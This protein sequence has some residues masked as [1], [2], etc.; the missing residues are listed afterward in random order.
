MG[1]RKKAKPN[2]KAEA[3]IPPPTPV[4]PEAVPLPETPGPSISSDIPSE[5]QPILA[6]QDTQTATSAAAN[7]DEP[8]PP[9]PTKG[10]LGGT[11]PRAAKAAPITQVAKKSIISAGKVISEV[12]ESAAANRP[13]TPLGQSSPLKAPSL[14]LS[15]KL[16]TSSRSLPVSA[17]TTK[18]N[19]SSSNLSRPPETARRKSFEGNPA[20][21]AAGGSIVEEK[22]IP[23]E[24]R[25]TG[26]E[27]LEGP[28]QSAPGP[29]A[30]RPQE[31]LGGNQAGWL[32]WFSRGDN[33]PNGSAQAGPDSEN[34]PEGQ[35][36]KAKEEERIKPAEVV[37]SKTSVQESTTAVPDQ[38]R[39][40]GKDSES[41]LTKT[42]GRIEPPPPRSW[43]PIWGT[44]GAT[45]D[46]STDATENINAIAAKPEESE[47]EPP[48]IQAVSDG[49]RD[50]G[51]SSG[52]T[53]WS[54]GNARPATSDGTSQP[55]LGKLAVAGSSSESQPKT[56]VVAG[57]KR[58]APLTSKTLKRERPQSLQAADDTT[59]PSA[60]IT[61]AN[62]NSAVAVQAPPEAEST[63]PLS[64]KPLP[65]AAPG[66]KNLIL[67]PLKRT[68]KPANNPGLLEQ[69]RS[70][71]YVA[72]ASPPKHVNLI[73]KP[74]PIKKAL[75][76]GVHGYFP[77]PLL[78]SVLGQPTGTSIKFAES[79]ATAIQKWTKNHGYTC[80]V[81]KIALE[82][83]GKIE[84]RVELLW[85]LLLNWMDAIT[86]ADFILV[87]CHS[88]GVPVAIMLVAK[89][90]SFGCLHGARIGIC[91][92]AGVNLGPFADYKSRWISG[93]AGELFEFARPD[94]TVSKDYEAALGG[95]VRYGVKILYIGS[96]D[97]QLVS[98]EV[99][100]LDFYKIHDRS[101]FMYP[102]TCRFGGP[103]PHYK[104]LEGAARW[105]PPNRQV[106]GYIPLLL[107]F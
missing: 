34:G 97:D 23:P 33:G 7:A 50:T 103:H 44:S 73:E 96:I 87:A 57:H 6:N 32:G 72:K 61:N 55:T 107:Q 14:Y 19:V 46:Q 8:I 13:H 104:G 60:S 12:A 39:G 45:S 20:E 59:T 31:N 66:A 52:W 28:Q 42:A 71:L 47:R 74:L 53:F 86:K 90:I 17:T 91:A 11:W 38:V 5:Y 63:K 93:S 1:P 89:L 21:L 29:A 68:Y 35:G 3:D 27:Q 83:E 40:D 62:G 105:W 26:S 106:D 2:P 85:K 95:V 18:V 48:E 54:R 94:S 69:L 37:K 76:I 65:D 92:M 56:A 98:L 15:G 25:I 9:P 36:T 22:T 84:E 67:P 81:E 102:L 70:L 88:Q 82:G 99:G 16:G 30:V 80:E 41:C 58:G 10:W 64:A 101:A 51:T 24:T 4:A 43:L 75:A 49:A 78:R 77:A 100:N 79:S